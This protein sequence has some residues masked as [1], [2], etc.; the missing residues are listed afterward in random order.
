MT[1]TNVTD[2]N[3]ASTEPVRETAEAAPPPHGPHHHP[4]DHRPNRLYQ[5]AAWVAIVAGVL[6]IVGAIFFTGF[7]LGR[8]SG[9]DG[10]M[11]GPRHHGGGMMMPRPMGDRD[12]RGPG[13]MGPGMMGPGMMGPGTP[14]PGGPGMR[15]PG[16][17]P[18]TSIPA[19]T[20]SAPPPS[21]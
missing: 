18:S 5:A 9:S 15:G 8:Y 7:T 16:A 14:G 13:M 19:P 6:F 21:R 20:P 12:D 4:H 17:A 2:S 11:G 3:E 10:G 1:D